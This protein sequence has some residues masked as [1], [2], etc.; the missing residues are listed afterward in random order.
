MAKPIFQTLT[1]D[2]NCGKWTLALQTDGWFLMDK[3]TRDE[4]FMG[5]D[6]KEA[7]A[8]ASE[9]IKEEAS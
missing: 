2:S 5:E 8:L 6:E 1:Y 7:L 9:F 3:E 4:Y